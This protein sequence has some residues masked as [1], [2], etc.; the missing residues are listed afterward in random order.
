[1]IA[2]QEQ[3]LAL[4]SEERA[5]IALKV[6]EQNRRMVSPIRRLEGNRQIFPLSFAQRRLWFLTHLDPQSR[7][8][9]SQFTC[10]LNGALDHRALERSFTELVRRHAI[11]RTTFALRDEQPVQIVGPVVPITIPIEDLGHLSE[12]ERQARLQAAIRDESGRPFDLAQGP[13]IRLRLSTLSAEESVLLLSFHHII[14]DG[15]SGEIITRELNALYR[16]FGRGESSPLPELPIQ[17]TDF[18][19]WQS[20]WLEGEVLR[21]QL[22]YWK[23]QLRGAPVTLGLIPDLPCPQVRNH[24]GMSWRRQVSAETTERLRILSRQERVSLFMTLLAAFL[25]LLY[26]YS[27]QEDLVVG[28]PAANRNR[29]ETEGLI[30]FFVNT[31]VLR[32]SLSGDPTFRDLLRR[33][34][35][36]TLGAYAHQDLPFEKLVEELQPE[37]SLGSSPLFQVMFALQNISKSHPEPDHTGFKLQL[38][39]TQVT[40]FDLALFCFDWWG[41]IDVRLEYST[42][43]FLPETA[44]RMLRHY[45]TLLESL[46]DDPGRSISKASLLS[47]DEIRHLIHLGGA[48]SQPM[49]ECCVHQLFEQQVEITPETIALVHEDQQ[50]SYRELN[51]RANRLAHQLRDLGVVPDARVALC[52]ERSLEMVVALLAILKAGGSYVPLDPA[53]PPERLAYMLEESSPAVLLTG[54]AFERDSPT[55]PILRLNTDAAQWAGRSED[56]PDCTGVNPRNLVYLIYTSGSTGQPKGAMN[57][58]RSVVNRLVWMQ[59]AYGLESHDAVLQKT[60]FSFDV[61]VWEFFWPLLYGGR[62]VMARPGGHR[63]PDYLAQVI[64]QQQITTVH[65]VPSMLQAF[66]ECREITRCRSLAR[67]ICSGETLPTALAQRFYEELP[68]A[69]LHN[70]YGPTEAAIDVTAWDCQVVGRGSWTRGASLPIGR[71]IANTFIY[72]LDPRRQLTLPGVAGEIYIGGAQVGRGYLNRPELTEERFL[73]DPFSQEP[74]ARMYKTGDLGRWLPDGSLEFLGRLDSQ[75]KIRGFRIELGEIEASLTSHPQVREAVV[76]AREDHQCGKRL[77]AYYTGAE[78]RKIGAEG[79]RAHL[80]SMLPEYMVSAAYIHLESLPVTHNG[81]LDRQAL[82]VPKGESYVRRDY[83]APVS[84]TEIRLARIW[85]DVLRLE[86]VGR[87]D[88]FFELG[89]HSLLAVTLIERMRREG[90]SSDVRSIFIAPTLM[91]LAEEIGSGTEAEIEVPLNLIPPGCRTITPDMLPLVRLTQSEIDS[92][93]AGVPGGAANVQDLYPLTPLQEGLLFHHLIS[94]SGDAYLLQSLL[95][96]EARDRLDDFVRALQAVIARHDILRTAIVWEGLTEPVQVVWREAP[97]MIE[98]IAPGQIVEEGQAEGEGEIARQLRARY[99]SRQMRLDLRQAP[100]MRCIVT[101]DPVNERWLLLWLSHHLTIDHT[102]IEIMLQEAQSL[103]L[104]VADR[105][106]EPPPF[107]NFVAHARLGLTPTEHEVFF[108]SM[109]GDIDEPTAPFGLLDARSDGEEVKELRIELEAILAGRLRERARF[110]GVST[111]SLCHLAWA[112]VLARVSGRDDVVFGTVLIGR[113]HGGA[114]AD[115]APGLFINTLPV[116]VR[117][118]PEPA[119]SSVKQLHT[120]LAELLR[121]EHASLALAQRCSG[122]K[123][124]TPLFSSLFNYRHRSRREEISPDAATAWAGIHLLDFEERTNYPLTLSIDDLGDSF[125]LTVQ[126]V[127][128]IDPGRI[129]GYLRTAL[130]QLMEKLEEAPETEVRAIEVL[131]ES[132]RRLLLKEWGRTG[133]DALTASSRREQSVHELFEEQVEASPEA[134]AVVCGDEQLSYA[135]LNAQANRLAHHLQGAGVGPDARVAICL[136]KGVEMVVALLATL[137]A[138]GAYVPLDPAYPPDRLAYILKDSAPTVL[139]IHNATLAALATCPPGPRIVN[140]DDDLW[141][142]ACQPSLNPNGKDPGLKAGSLAYIIYTSGSTGLPKGV[143]IEHRGLSNLAFAQ[144]QGFAVGADSRVLQFASFSFDAS[145]FELT[146]ALCR[147]AALV[148]PPRSVMVAGEDLIHTLDLYRISHVLLPPAVLATLPPVDNF[149]SLRELIVG[150]EALTAD[151]AQTWS[152]G[153]RVINAYGPTEGTVLA[154]QYDCHDDESGAPPIGRPIANVQGYVLDEH[155]RV[156]PV[157]VA[158]EIYLGGAGVARG[159]LDR[160]ELTAERFVPDPFIEEPGARMYRTGDVGRWLPTGQ[161][162]FLGR[163]DFQVKIRGFRVE[164]GEIEAA[165]RSYSGVCQAVVLSRD[166]S[167]LG[168]RLIAFYSGAELGPEALRA[169]LTSRLPEYM[170]PAAYVYLETMPLTP[171]GK[172][173]R[174]ALFALEGRPLL[175]SRYDPPVGETETQLARIWAEVLKLDRVGRSD[176]FFDLGGHSLLAMTVIERMRREGMS[177]D[178]GALFTTPTLMALAEAVADGEDPESQRF[179]RFWARKLDGAVPSHVPRLSKPSRWNEGRRITVWEM[180]LPERV[181]DGLRQFAILSGLPVKTVLLTSHLKVLSLLTGETEILTG[182]SMND[183]PETES[184]GWGKGLFL[185]NVPFRMSIVGG[186]WADLARTVFG[187]ERDLLPYCRHPLSASRKRWGRDLQLETAFNYVG[188]QAVER[189]M[190]SQRARILKAGPGSD[191]TRFVLLAS[192]QA[193]VEDGGGIH[194]LLHCDSTELVEPQQKAIL[195]CYES[196]LSSMAADPVALHS[197]LT[198]E[199]LISDDEKRL[200]NKDISIDALAQPFNF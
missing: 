162:E 104:G 112:Q 85:A 131:P 81:K 33:V 165:L 69:K 24:Q 158:G 185:D 139:L 49:P 184:G 10:R 35:A 198:T 91:S 28:T 163:N 132:E 4:K 178:V 159:Y 25:A 199:S 134:V 70:L 17:Y 8:C 138:G 19:S 129:Y 128:P 175:H 103:L 133:A 15:W 67:V 46:V 146:M 21:G 170:V 150:G 168:K 143:M 152:A 180:R 190:N 37:R 42:E 187:E 130:E 57:E 77:V 186:T 195:N 164:L 189:I 40:Q 83:E 1:M 166:E 36:V 182:L 101:H 13:L 174:R 74:Q 78:G 11:L 58:H 173:D 27:G 89:G 167:E 43:L 99:S 107:R 111:A 110:L 53:S 155:R 123:A 192:F 183:G 120:L 71:P 26:R 105:L 60:P 61:S 200:I 31:L 156:A 98:E 179:R 113:M 147:G 65:F 124:P 90:L 9:L 102:T 63:D 160:P 52:L 121:H 51:A 122:V 44:E 66:L 148:L 106:P 137:K 95:G 126:V 136:E 153:R 20:E 188:F 116:R 5:A 149:N 172:L 14:G 72:I 12:A 7:L 56:N 157:G 2:S 22:E 109:L 118:G 34:K 140:L 47:A 88:N 29:A 145:I 171:S 176:N 196:V 197:M 119:A 45:P 79:L 64:Q 76:V 142:W 127:R 73:P 93:V 193:D 39:E 92:I 50:L 191:E 141:E 6:W 86:R 82:P 100:L 87:H 154:T 108:R 135:A 48:P 117:I 94:V 55:L 169:H 97:M 16:A 41:G 125:V 177:A 30:G 62:L 114:G 194:L 115:R 59:Q 84:E 96:F 68:E 54:E 161:I 75:V 151:L 23:A 18:A 181:C 38:A 3:E 144:I 32:T 80:S